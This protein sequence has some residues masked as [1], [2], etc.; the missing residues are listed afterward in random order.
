[1][2]TKAYW[3]FQLSCHMPQNSK[4]ESVHQGPH[5]SLTREADSSSFRAFFFLFKI[6]VTRAATATQGFRVP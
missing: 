5:S 1:M 6:N 2:E 4:D 3:F